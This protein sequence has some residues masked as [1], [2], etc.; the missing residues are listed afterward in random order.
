MV[1]ERENNEN[2]KFDFLG[3]TFRAIKVNRRGQNSRHVLL[4]LN[5]RS[6]SSKAVK[7]MRQT[8]R[9]KIWE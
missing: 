5:P 6:V 2:T 9:G 4:A 8:T 3:Y 7:M 1:K